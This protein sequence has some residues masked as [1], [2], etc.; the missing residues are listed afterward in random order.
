MVF[1]LIVV[2]E[3][4]TS[5]YVVKII[6]YEICSSLLLTVFMWLLRSKLHVFESCCEVPGFRNKVPSFRG[7][8]HFAFCYFFLLKTRKHKE[9]KGRKKKFFPSSLF[10]C[11]LISFLFFLWFVYFRTGI[12]FPFASPHVFVHACWF[13]LTL[14]M[15]CHHSCSIAR[16][17]ILR[18]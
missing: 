2:R 5:T 1:F 9:E 16:A 11:F 15:F 13:I 17:W 14:F 7:D 18:T 12:F 6:S 8:V 3:E 4:L 10:F